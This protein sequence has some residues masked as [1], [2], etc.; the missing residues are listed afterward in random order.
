MDQ[1]LQNKIERLISVRLNRRRFLSAAAGASVIAVLPFSGCS[2]DSS[3]K[4]SF[5]FSKEQ[6]RTLSAVQERLLPHE[7]NSPGASDINA[8]D[9]LEMVL[10]QP[11]FDPEIR[12]FIA[13]GLKKLIP[14][15]KENRTSRFE[16]MD[17]QEQESTLTAVQDLNWG[18]TW[19]SL[20]LLYIFEALL[21]DPVYGGNPDGIGWTWLEHTPGLPRPVESTRYGAAI[22][23]ENIKR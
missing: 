15:N 12:D 14:F 22:R 2:P 19:T 10:N 1:L 21:S 11:G 8:A 5:V 20:I 4:K 16:A 7:E 18:Q 9:Y 23:K 6:K 3:S 13:D 17:A